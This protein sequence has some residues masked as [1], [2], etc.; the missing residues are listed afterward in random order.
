MSKTNFTRKY[1]ESKHL[2]LAERKILFNI[3]RKSKRCKQKK[4]PFMSKHTMARMLGVSPQ[5]IKEALLQ[6]K[7]RSITKL[8][9]KMNMVQYMVNMYTRQIV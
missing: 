8:S 7:E 6:L 3:L 4:R 9:T 2:T 1:K 5:T